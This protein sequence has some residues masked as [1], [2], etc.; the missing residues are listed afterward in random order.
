MALGHLLKGAGARAQVLT[1]RDMVGLY[2]YRS[3]P[4]MA[5]GMEKNSLVLGHYSLVR[6]LLACA[7]H[8]ALELGPLAVLVM[9]ALRGPASLIPWSLGLA[10]L[11]V[12]IALVV[13]RWA[14][15]PLLPAA[16]QPLGAALLAVLML[17]AG[18]VTTWRGGVIWRGTVYPLDVLRA[19]MRLRLR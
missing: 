8:A 12:G 13:N 3:L 7:T 11:A 5:R 19:G 9:A 14:G 16:L 18:L 1:A 4:E 2:F 15:R 6:L 10:V 17:R